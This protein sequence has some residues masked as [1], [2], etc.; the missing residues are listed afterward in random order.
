MPRLKIH[1]HIACRKERKIDIAVAFSNKRRERERERENL[2]SM[3]SL[4]PVHT[5]SKISDGK[6]IKTFYLVLFVYLTFLITKSL[7]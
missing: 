5:T 2:D 6:K 4:T 7:I 1:G 3:R